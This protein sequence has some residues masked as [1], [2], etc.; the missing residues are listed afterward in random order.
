MLVLYFPFLGVNPL[1]SISFDSYF[2]Y[3]IYCTMIIRKRHHQCVVEREWMF[4][5][6]VLLFGLSINFLQ[7][8]HRVKYCTYEDIFTTDFLIRFA[9][10]W[11][12]PIGF[13]SE[14]HS[15][16]RYTL[17]TSQ[18]EGFSFPTNFLT[19]F[20]GSNCKRLRCPKVFKAEVQTS[21]SSKPSITVS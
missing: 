11:W 14:S 10:A 1:L 18:S 13:V 6:R 4:T 19:S 20:L 12:T 16:L 7:I 9:V 17:P 5:Y 2:V 8:I 15:W 21:Q 3:F